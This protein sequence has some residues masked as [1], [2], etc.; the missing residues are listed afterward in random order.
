MT[1]HTFI[2]LAACTIA[3]GGC[4]F[5][6]QTEPTRA[7]VGVNT[8]SEPPP[9]STNESDLEVVRVWMIDATSLIAAERQ[10]PR[11]VAASDVV[12]ALAAG[13]T[14]EES[15]RGLRSAIPE[16]SMVVDADVSR[17][18][19][20][21]LLSDSFRDIPAGDQV[22]AVAQIVFTLT[23]L[24]GVGRVRFEIGGEP[25][26]VPLPDGDSIDASVSRDDFEELLSR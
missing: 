25:V 14:T 17:G 19:A 10:L 5:P 4:G 13:V 6:T 11:P 24:R 3:L 21:V 23:D 26:A 20:T 18:T 7:E 9:T 12:A 22:F 1:R 16:V 8:V 15:D 2:R